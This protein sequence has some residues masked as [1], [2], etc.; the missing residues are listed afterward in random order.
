M[1]SPPQPTITDQPPLCLTT[2][3]VNTPRRHQLCSVPVFNPSPPTRGA[4]HLPSSSYH[5]EAPSTLSTTK[6]AIKS[7]QQ[8]K[9]N[10]TIPHQTIHITI[11]ARTHL[12]TETTITI[13]QITKLSSNQPLHHKP[14]PNS[15]QSPITDHHTNQSKQAQAVYTS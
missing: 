5:R 11:S 10:S 2:K 12:F 3:P 8:T 6:P 13:K 7:N 4:S 9:P 14:V 15:T 1:A